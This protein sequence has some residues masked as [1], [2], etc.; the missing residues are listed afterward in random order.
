MAAQD[1]SHPTHRP[2]QSGAAANDTFGD[3]I[4]RTLLSASKA[5]EQEHLA[6]LQ[7]REQI[8]QDHVAKLGFAESRPSSVTKEAPELKDCTQATPRSCVD[9]LDEDSA[10]DQHSAGHRTGRTVDFLHLNLSVRTE[11]QG[12]EPI[13]TLERHGSMSQA[14]TM[15]YHLLDDWVS[16]PE[17]LPDEDE[18]QFARMQYLASLGRMLRRQDTS[19]TI[20]L[21]LGRAGI[22][23]S[24]QPRRVWDV[25]AALMLAYDGFLTPMMVFDIPESTFTFVMGVSVM[26]YWTVDMCLSFFAG[27][28]L[29]DGGL[30][31]RCRFTAWRY[32]ITWFGL[33]L[34]V[35]AVD[36]MTLGPLLIDQSTGGSSRQTAG[37][38]RLGKVARFLRV[39]RFIRLIRLG[40]IGKMLR[41]IHNLI[42]M[43]STAIIFSIVKNICFIFVINHFLACLWFYL[44]LQQEHDG[45]LA[46]WGGSSEDWWHNYALSLHWSIS[47]FTPGSSSSS[48][49][50]TEEVAFAIIVLFFALVV[51]SVF[52]SSTTSL[53][54]RL[55]NMKSAQRRQIWI[56]KGFLQQNKVPTDLKDRVMRYVTTALGTRRDTHRR[57][58]V[59]LLSLLSQPLR[60]EVQTTL[61]LRTLHVHPFFKMLSLSGP[62]LLRKL[63]S[64]ALTEMS[65][66]H[67]DMIFALG[68]SCDKMGFL[69]SGV[70]EYMHIR[71]SS[72]KPLQESTL[73]KPGTFF[74]EAVLWTKWRCRGN[75]QAD[76]DCQLLELSGT[77]FRRCAKQHRVVRSLVQDYAKA[78]IEALNAV[79]SEPDLQQSCLHEEPVLKFFSE[80]WSFGFGISGT[81]LSRTGALGI[82]HWT[83]G[84]GSGTPHRSHQM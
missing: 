19:S 37:L 25:L 60:E 62:S 20:G 72:G 75:M 68:E 15:T 34:L 48:P 43:E 64:E 3:H 2:S 14:A 27:Y 5:L 11:G 29:P 66:S 52:V 84:V 4:L 31:L 83:S 65:F 77:A 41:H 57:S 59:E 16:N 56:L 80:P 50:T 10:E 6:I 53:I 45:W 54:S 38:L 78:F 22:S 18:T 7:Q 44:G 8:H 55:V 69:E 23:P 73:C 71:K 39:L 74:C 1:D 47:N 61:H 24:S 28:E 12:I 32:L 33:D 30:E 36:W 42:G 67:G 76:S 35:L 13:S 82:S 81:P 51:F 49:R 63:S 17:D 70:L 46:A 9:D 40:K 79:A 21:P 26:L 58:D